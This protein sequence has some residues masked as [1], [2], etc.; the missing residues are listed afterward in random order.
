MGGVSNGCPDV[1][2]TPTMVKVQAPAGGS[3]Y[4]ID[5]TEVTN[6]QYV[7]WAE[8]NPTVQ[9]TAACEWNTVFLPPTAPP[10]NSHP[11]ANVDWCDA[12]AFCISRGKRLCGRID[13]GDL[14]YAEVTDTEKSQWHNACTAGGTKLF[15]YGDAYDAAAC[16]GKE[17]DAGNDAA[18]PVKS[19][20]TCEGGFPEIFDMSGNVWEWEDACDATAGTSPQENYCR[21]RGGGHTS[22]DVDLDCSTASQTFMRSQSNTNT[23]FRCC[24]DLP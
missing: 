23:G 15:P 14:G 17:K 21:R 6:A 18:V 12:Y 1:P 3:D 2:D 5:S 4:C 24:A 10:K 16:N 19:V 20:G 8:G 22:A 11:I 13:G 9:Q 7:K